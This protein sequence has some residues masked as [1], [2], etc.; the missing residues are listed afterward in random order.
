MHFQNADLARGSSDTLKNLKGV[1]TGNGPFGEA[2]GWSKIIP[3]P[4]SQRHS[5]Y[6]LFAE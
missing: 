6:E 4:F 2:K 3:S 5:D 1:S